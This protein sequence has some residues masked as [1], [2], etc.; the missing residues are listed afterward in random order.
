MNI[1]KMKCLALITQHIESIEVGEDGK[2]HGSQ[3]DVN[4]PIDDELNIFFK[5][6]VAI[7]I[8]NFITI[9]GGLKII[10]DQHH[11]SFKM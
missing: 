7:S 9:I 3:I 2:Y 4:E 5:D 8:Y 1:V 10:K 11:S 6:I